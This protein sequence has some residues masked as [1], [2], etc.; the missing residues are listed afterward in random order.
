MDKVHKSYAWL[1]IHAP[2]ALTWQK[3]GKQPQLLQRKNMRTQ[4][5]K[6]WQV[7]GETHKCLHPHSGALASRGEKVFKTRYER[8]TV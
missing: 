6:S 2:F 5:C 1:R 3:G 4:H 8:I 7:E